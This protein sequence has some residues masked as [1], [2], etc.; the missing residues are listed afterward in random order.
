MQET[1]AQDLRGKI[2]SPEQVKRLLG[3]E[4]PKCE[5]FAWDRVAYFQLDGNILQ[6]YDGHD[7]ILP[8]PGIAMSATIMES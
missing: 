8:A 5:G 4:F 1:K 7:Q 3:G 6:S 2:F